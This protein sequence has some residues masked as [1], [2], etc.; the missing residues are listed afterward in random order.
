MSVFV[1][2]N[3]PGRDCGRFGASGMSTYDDWI[4]AFARGIGDGKALVIFEPDSLANLPGDCLKSDLA[5]NSENYP[6]SDAQRLA[7]V[8]DAVRVLEA[9]P[10][11]SVY[12]DAG[13]STW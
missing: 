7:E 13:D 3:I 4:G 2:F 5:L 10:H 9:D 6:F 11:V 12:L 1:T 8:K